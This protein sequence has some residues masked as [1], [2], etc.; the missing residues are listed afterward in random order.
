M[1][2]I[3]VSL[4]WV[5]TDGIYQLEAIVLT[6]SYME[7]RFVSWKSSFIQ[8]LLYVKFRDRNPRVTTGFSVTTSRFQVTTSPSAVTTLASNQLQSSESPENSNL[9]IFIV[10]PVAVVAISLIIGAL[11]G[12]VYKKLSRKW[13]ASN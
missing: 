3:Q 10:V 9:V 7:I 12:L 13:E 5:T 6:E 2:G 11:A 1:T 4:D 8:G